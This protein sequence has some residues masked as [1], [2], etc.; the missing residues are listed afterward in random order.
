MNKMITTKNG[1]K[2]K[3]TC[4]NKKVSKDDLLVEVVG[5]IDEL[6]AILEMVEE[7]EVVDDLRN[8]MGELGG[9]IKFLISDF[10]FSTNKMEE[11]IKKIP[12]VKSFLKFKSQ[13]ALKL[14]WARTVCRRVERRLV[15][16][17]KRDKIDQN[18]LKYFN[19]LS[20]Y[21][22]VKAIKEN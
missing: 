3:T 9:G 22:F 13:R 20:D 21:L 5:S 7:N 12:E 19:R 16:L 4:G 8:I 14:N 11:E 18:I 10:Q 2:G 15:S 6:Q 17:Q 1:D